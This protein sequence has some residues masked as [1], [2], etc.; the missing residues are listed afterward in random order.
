[1]EQEEDFVIVQD[2]SSTSLQECFQL[3]MNKEELDGDEKPV[4]ENERIDYNFVHL[5]LY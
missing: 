3:F 4:K 5:R 2:K 1:M